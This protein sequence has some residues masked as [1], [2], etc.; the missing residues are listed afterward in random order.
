[1]ATLPK[2]IDSHWIWTYDGKEW[3]VV[4]CGDALAPKLFL[5][6]RR[7]PNEVACDTFRKAGIEYDPH[8]NYLKDVQPFERDEL[9]EGEDE[10]VKMEKQRRVA[11]RQG[12]PMLEPARYWQNVIE[13]Q[14]LAKLTE[15]PTRKK[16]RKHTGDGSSQSS[17]SSTKQQRS[18][19]GGRQL[20][21]PDTTPRKQHHNYIG[22][23]QRNRS[24]GLVRREEDDDES[25]F[26]ADEDAAK[27][28]HEN[29]LDEF[30]QQ[31][32]HELST[33]PPKTPF[34]FPED[35]IRESELFC[36]RTKF[37]EKTGSVVDI[38]DIEKVTAIDF[39]E[40]NEYLRYGDFPPPLIEKRN[41]LPR[42][43][44]LILPEEKDAAAEKCARVF[45]TASYLELGSLQA[46]CLN[47]LRVLYPLSPLRILIVAKYLL[48][49]VAWGC[50]A[51]TEYVD[52]MIDHISEYYLLLVKQY[53]PQLVDILD[54]SPLIKGRVMANLSANPEM[55]RR[56]LD[57]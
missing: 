36:G 35:A 27:H 39:V 44:G 1:M 10:K 43:D 37:T 5:E 19:H 17:F 53:G 12:A 4:L 21:T 32:E 42:I 28:E 47:K 11:F 2:H 40:V 30:R 45:R 56:G 7:H 48:R 46:L 15:K 49:S 23:E 41:S 38:S 3:P 26:I 20:L 54:N 57:D 8:E 55:G 29:D 22:G 34:Q 14:R 16:K 25:L 50:E 6:T 9:V 51:E 18:S 33:S 52:W 24:I 13:Q 31:Y